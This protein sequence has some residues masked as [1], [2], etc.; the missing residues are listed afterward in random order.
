MWQS[1]R[2]PHP[3]WSGVPSLAVEDQ[4]PP[5]AVKAIVESAMVLGQECLTRS[6]SQA[7]ITTGVSLLLHLLAW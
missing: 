3:R 2:E 1:W 7:H 6:H 4:H 5:S